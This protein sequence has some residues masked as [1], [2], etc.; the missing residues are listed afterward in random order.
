[1][2]TYDARTVERNWLVDGVVTITD[3]PYAVVNVP[4][5]APQ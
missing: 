2:A 4:M 3:V 1:M 5:A